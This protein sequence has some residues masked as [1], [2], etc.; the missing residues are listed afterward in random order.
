MTTAGTSPCRNS[1]Y[2]TARIATTFDGSADDCA[3]PYS[4]VTGKEEAPKTGRLVPGNAFP[5]PNPSLS[6]L[7]PLTPA[8]ASG[9]SVD[10]AAFKACPNL[11]ARL[12][13]SRK[14]F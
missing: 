10:S 12:L 5:P 11:V 4:R 2:S 8:H 14:H 13:V 9:L 7:R 6:V 1:E 3:E